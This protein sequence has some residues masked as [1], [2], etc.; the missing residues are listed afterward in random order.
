MRRRSARGSGLRPST[1]SG[2]EVSLDRGTIVQILPLGNGSPFVVDTNGDGTPDALDSCPAPAGAQAAS[3]SA[4]P[5]CYFVAVITLRFL[6]QNRVTGPGACDVA[7][8]VS[9]PSVNDDSPHGRAMADRLGADRASIPRPDADPRPQGARLWR[10]VGT[11]NEGRPQG[12]ALP[13]GGRR[14]PTRGGPRFPTWRGRSFVAGSAPPPE[15]RR[16]RRGSVHERWP[17]IY[18]MARPL[19]GGGLR[20]T[21]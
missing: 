19:L 15:P 10:R 21:L 5:E 8:E 20:P 14:F 7:R 16:L 17:T 1:L 4:L 2:L 6:K 11:G 12:A 3:K 13:G 18:R 9:L